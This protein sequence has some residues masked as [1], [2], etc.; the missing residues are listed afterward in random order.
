MAGVLE[1]A[2]ELCLSIG[3]FCERLR[4]RLVPHDSLPQDVGVLIVVHEVFLGEV[5]ILGHP[6]PVGRVVSGLRDSG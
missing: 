2:I 1:P 5:H 4:I 6:C 3:S